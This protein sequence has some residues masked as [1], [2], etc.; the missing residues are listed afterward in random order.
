MPKSFTFN[1]I[2]KEW[3]IATEGRSK[4]PFASIHRQTITVPGMPGAHLQRSDIQPMTIN[5]PI[6][7]MVKDDEHALQLKDELANWLITEEPVPLEFDDEPGRIYYAVVQNTLDDFSRFAS[8]REGTIQ[9]LLTD[10]HGYG[11]EQG[12]LEFEDDA[13]T[14]N[15]EGT[16]EAYPIIEATA[17][18]SS[19]SFMITK[20]DQDYFMVGQPFDIESIPV[21]RYPEVARYRMESTLGWSHMTSGFFLDDEVSGGTVSGSNIEVYNGTSF[22]PSG[23]GSGFSGWYGPAVRRSFPTSVQ[24]FRFV[25][26]TAIFNNG[27]GVGKV[28][29]IFLD[30]DDDIVCSIGLINSR[31]G[32]KNVR[33]LARMN[34]GDNIRRRRIMD[35]QGDTGPESTVFNGHPL[36][37][38]IK[39]EGTSFS[40]RTWQVKG[41]VP[42]ARHSDSF[43]DDNP[44][45][46]RPVRQ[47]VLFF[48]RYGQT[49]VFPMYIYGLRIN[50]SNLLTEDDIPYIC[51]E[52]DTIRIDSQNEVIMINDDEATQ[53]K[54]FGSNYFLLDKG[55]NHLLTYPMGAFDTIIKWKNRYK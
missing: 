17:K 43:V 29:A 12:P 40:A 6:G 45:F 55:E 13:I 39:R 28:M 27:N 25:L 49:P 3:L 7:F 19:T 54:D 36:N 34:D 35:Y 26:G 16:A 22:R 51:H 50:E 30:E 24:D 11:N 2:R 14:I 37:I 8:L 41:G 44:D 23:F 53:L 5:Q 46:Q 9:F 10:P 1:G 20:G 21:D 31:L 4:P 38:E 42:V 52:G 47:V 18:E 32:S 48:A 15:N 33:V